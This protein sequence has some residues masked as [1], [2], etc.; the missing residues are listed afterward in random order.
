MIR[1]KRRHSNAGRIILFLNWLSVICLILSYASTHISPEENSFLPFFGLSFP[2]WFAFNVLF[3]LLWL[4]RRK[5]AIF[6]SLIALLFGMNHITHFIQFSFSSKPN[7]SANYF[8]ILSHNV[9]LFGLYEWENNTEIRDKI[10]E[11]LKREDPD[12]MCFQEFYYT[13]QKDV[14]ET[15]DEILSWE[16]GM[17]IHEKYT[18][19][20][21]HHQFFGIVTVSKYP[22]VNKGYIEFG[23]DRNN[24]CI[25]SDIVIHSDTVRIYNT[26]L[27]SIRFQ[28]EDY[29]FIDELKNNTKDFSLDK[30]LAIFKRLKVA[31]IKR[32]S[33]IEKVMKNIKKSPYP[34]VLVG[35]FNDTPISYTYNQARESLNDAFIESGNGIGN[36]YI[37]A[38]PS[39]RIDY[40]LHSENI[41][42]HRF[43]SL[44]DKLSDHH[45]I[46][47]ILEVK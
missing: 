5:R 47:A 17:N 37:G 14:F 25:Y 2:I 21:I 18:H 46:T 7:N 8:K 20:L 29:E 11:L 41:Q 15:R 34:T 35:D 42:S 26:H 23:N 36:T 1:K 16:D 38:F 31:Y 44:E 45:P 39:F 30:S 33:Q 24:F 3:V 9:K 32:A 13:E 19:E 6:I 10:F 12:I 22:I 43:K 40:I 28:K 4:L 27:S